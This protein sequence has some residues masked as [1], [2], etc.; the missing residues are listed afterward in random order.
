MLY[1]LAI[2]FG[3]FSIAFYSN[4]PSAW[5]LVVLAL[6][7][8]LLLGFLEIKH[9]QPPSVTLKVSRLTALFAFGSIWGLKVAYDLQYHRPPENFTCTAWWR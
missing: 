7:S 3:V 1:L 6:S 8:V 9:R 4:L 5:V 2:S